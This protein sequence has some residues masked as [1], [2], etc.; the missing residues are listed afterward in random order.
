MPLPK[1]SG[2]ELEDFVPNELIV[3]QAPVSLIAKGDAAVPSLLVR[4]HKL[5]DQQAGYI[6]ADVK[7]KTGMLVEIPRSLRNRTKVTIATGCFDLLEAVSFNGLNSR[8][9][10]MV[11]IKRPDVALRVEY[12]NKNHLTCVHYHTF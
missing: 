6:I 10:L 11:L 9:N 4:Y 2:F 8:Q 7:L 3:D 12:V 1:Y 5:L